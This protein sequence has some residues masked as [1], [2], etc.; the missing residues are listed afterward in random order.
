MVNHFL[1]DLDVEKSAKFVCDAHVNKMLLETCQLLYTAWHENAV[2]LPAVADGEAPPYK[3]AHKN[4]PTAIWTRAHKNNYDHMIKYAF[5]LNKEAIARYPD[6]K[7]EH[8]CMQHIRRL[9]VWGYPKKE[10][11]VEPPLKRRKKKQTI[12][13][14][15]DL[16]VGLTKLPLCMPEEYM[17]KKGDIYSAV[18]SYVKYYK[19][20]EYTMKRKMTWKRLESKPSWI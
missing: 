7:T 3:A 11:V 8:K 12:Y 16:P 20:K 4:H 13:A 6:R 18:G 17:V 15:V 9:K 10:K 14:T 5:A 1:I 2:E 19:S